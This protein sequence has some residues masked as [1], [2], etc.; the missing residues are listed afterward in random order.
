MYIVTTPTYK[1]SDIFLLYRFVSFSFQFIYLTGN[2]L[3]T[4]IGGK[5]WERNRHLLT[6]AFHFDILKDYVNVFNEV[7]DELLVNSHFFQISQQTHNMSQ[8]SNNI[9]WFNISN[10]L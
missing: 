3:L 1:Q 5:G 6:P 9:L 7:T 8:P 4:H 10:V 2:G